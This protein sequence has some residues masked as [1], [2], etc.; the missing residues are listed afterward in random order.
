[1]F[2]HKCVNHKFNHMH[3]DN[4]LSCETAF[5]KSHKLAWTLAQHHVHHH[6]HDHLHHH[7]HISL[8]KTPFAG[9]QLPQWW[10]IVQEGRRQDCPSGDNPLWDLRPCEPRETWDLRPREQHLRREIGDHV[11]HILDHVNHIRRLHQSFAETFVKATRTQDGTSDQFWSKI[12]EGLR[13]FET[14]SG[15]YRQKHSY[16]SLYIQQ[17]SY[18]SLWNLI[19]RK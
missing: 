2:T 3:S 13:T 5:K 4:Q 1:M 6:V 16:Q 10:S 14:W 15:V 7:V 18:Q 8:S 19:L 12:W 9:E 11:N 17:H